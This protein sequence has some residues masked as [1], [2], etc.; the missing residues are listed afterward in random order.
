[1]GLKY[2]PKIPSVYKELK[3]RTQLR[4]EA[5][6]ECNCHMISIGSCVSSAM[7]LVN[8]YY[9]DKYFGPGPCLRDGIINFRSAH[10]TS[11]F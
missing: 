6:P 2:L 11:I 4:G 9:S 7:Y 5:G 1:M 10:L 3:R 8:L